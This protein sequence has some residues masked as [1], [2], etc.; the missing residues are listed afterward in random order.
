MPEKE[1][2]SCEMKVKSYTYERKLD[3]EVL[4]A[5][6]IPEHADHGQAY[7][8]LVERGLGNNDGKVSFGN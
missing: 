5:K 2:R 6:T 1:L 7:C 3:G 4:E 8:K